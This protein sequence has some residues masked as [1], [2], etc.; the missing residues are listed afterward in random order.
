MTDT[1]GAEVGI[2]RVLPLTIEQDSPWL[3]QLLPFGITDQFLERCNDVLSNGGG[4]NALFEIGILTEDDSR[5]NKQLLR[6]LPEAGDVI[7]LMRACTTLGWDVADVADNATVLLK[8]PQDALEV[9]EVLHDQDS[10]AVDLDIS[11]VVNGLKNALFAD[12][13]VELRQSKV[14]QGSSLGDTRPDQR[15]QQIRAFLS[16]PVQQKAVQSYREAGLDPTNFVS[17]RH[18]EWQIAEPEL[19]TQYMTTL[20][21]IL[22]TISEHSRAKIANDTIQS[23]YKL[24]AVLR[25]IKEITIIGERFGLDM[26]NMYRRTEVLRRKPRSVEDILS[27]RIPKLRELGL[28]EKRILQ[29]ISDGLISLSTADDNFNARLQ[30]AQRQNRLSISSLTDSG[31]KSFFGS[32]GAA[33]LL[34]AILLQKNLARTPSQDQIQDF[35]NRPHQLYKSGHTAQELATMAL[36][37]RHR[38]DQDEA[39]QVLLRIVEKRHKAA[40]TSD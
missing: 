31:I 2:E 27:D 15:A 25:N 11:L 3:D 30:I 10:D 35:I 19:A 4:Q 28:P 22:P 12:Q 17:Y 16:D 33:Y 13:I 32:R 26:D 23:G 7:R 39:A 21:S 38:F 24:E 5:R 40:T 18:G 34:V 37:Q 14:S 6:N 8:R 36:E 29:M 9:I 1:G 20:R